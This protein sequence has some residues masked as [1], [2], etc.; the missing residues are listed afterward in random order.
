M[1]KRIISILC[2]GAAVLPAACSIQK[3]DIQQGNVVDPAMLNQLH[4]GMNM[5]QV[6]FVMGTPLL[7][8]PF[9][10][11]RWDYEYYLRK[12]DTIVNHYDVTV[13]FQHGLVNRIVKHTKG[14]Q[15]TAHQ[16]RAR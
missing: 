3:I 5:R 15:E 14:K 8:D 10:K 9:H 12:D 11:D 16:A 13:Y 6:I 4:V 2:A 7:K 1:L